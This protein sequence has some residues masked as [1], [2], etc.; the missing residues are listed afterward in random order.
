MTYKTTSWTGALAMSTFVLLW[1]SAAIFT[2]WALDHCSVF[3]ILTLRYSLALGALLVIGLP[4]R[5]WLPKPGTR[6]LVAGT[7]LLLIGSYSVCY[8]QAIAHGVTPGLLATLLGIQPILTL[9]LT[10]RRFSTWR[11][12][13]LLL[14]LAGLLL[15]LAGL[16]LVVYQSL[17][18]AKL[19]IMG[20][21]F[22]FGGLLSMTVGALLQKRVQQTPSEVLPLQYLVALLLCLGLVPFES[23]HAEASPGFLIPLLYLGLVVSVG[24]QLLLYRLIRTGNLVNV[25][26]L[27]YLVPVVTVTLDYLV[28]GNA[29]PTLALLGMAAILVGLA[30]VFR[31]PT[32]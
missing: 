20:L 7:G 28:F 6:G 29:M 31:P 13:G 16:M 2:R 10:E 8:F 4:N 22:A 18:Q 5:R 24:A 9:L 32:H 15:S 14:S 21:A 11:L 12:L 27:F 23:F 19:S 3:A 17:M 1:G 30:M 26:S 25:T